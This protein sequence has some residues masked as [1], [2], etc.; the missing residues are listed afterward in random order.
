MFKGH[1]DERIDINPIN[2][3][4]ST[5]PLKLIHKRFGNGLQLCC[6][7]N[8]YCYKYGMVE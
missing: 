5:K 3:M 6:R 7:R 1:F 2:H 8:D 4:L